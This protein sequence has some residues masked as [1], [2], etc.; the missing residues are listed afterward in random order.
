MDNTAKKMWQ[1]P[2]VE[3]LEVSLTMEG[4]GTKVVDIVTPSD[5]DIYDPS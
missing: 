3:I 2:T 1:Q 4:K 5:L